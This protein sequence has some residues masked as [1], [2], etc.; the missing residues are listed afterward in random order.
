MRC[1]YHFFLRGRHRNGD[2][3][4]LFNQLLISPLYREPSISTGLYALRAFGFMTELLAQGRTPYDDR[5]PS[6]ETREGRASP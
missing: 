4:A 6:V 5:L 3:I 2:L 1:A